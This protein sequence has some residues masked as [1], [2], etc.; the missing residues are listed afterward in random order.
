MEVAYEGG[1]GTG[2]A[3]VLDAET[4]ERTSFD[5]RFQFN[6]IRYLIATFCRG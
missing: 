2:G 5:R 3:C 6:T 1:G 4:S